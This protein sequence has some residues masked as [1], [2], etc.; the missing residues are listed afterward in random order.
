[1]RQSVI[2][3]MCCW[4]LFSVPDNNQCSNQ[5][6]FIQHPISTITR[7]YAI[8]MSQSIIYEF[9]TTFLFQ[10]LGTHDSSLQ[11]LVHRDFPLT[12]RSTHDV[13][14]A[15]VETIDKVHI[16]YYEYGQQGGDTMNKWGAGD[17]KGTG[18]GFRRFFLVVFFSNCKTRVIGYPNMYA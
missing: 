3:R 15:E 6:S 9:Y 10:N 16:K 14:T 4:C 17:L 5:L 1:M 13:T 2:I 7:N 12:H 8:S 11:A 18:S